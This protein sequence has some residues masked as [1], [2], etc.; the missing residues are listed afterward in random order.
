LQTGPSKVNC[1]RTLFD[2]LYITSLIHRIVVRTVEGSWD[3]K[4]YVALMLGRTL[5]VLLLVGNLS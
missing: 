1:D 3:N 5:F 2:M 4:N